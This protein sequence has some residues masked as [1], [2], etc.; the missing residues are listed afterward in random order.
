MKIKWI[1]V[2][3][4]KGLLF[5]E[6]YSAEEAMLDISWSLRDPQTNLVVIFK[7]WEHRL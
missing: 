2:N 3:V 4:A 6:N 1:C 5:C 7:L